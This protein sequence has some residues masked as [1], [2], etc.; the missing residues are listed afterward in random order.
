MSIYR[1]DGIE[2][3]IITTTLPSGDVAIACPNSGP[4]EQIVFDL[5]R[6][7]GRRNANY[8]GWIVPM[9]KAGYVKLRLAEH[10]KL[11]AP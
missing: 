11:V 4:L 1:I 8:G 9:S 10:C 5:C 3:Q 6:W 2:G 7:S